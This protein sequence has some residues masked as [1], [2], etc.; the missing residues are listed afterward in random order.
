MCAHTQAE[1]QRKTRPSIQMK[2]VRTQVSGHGSVS[3]A[4][5]GAGS[6]PSAMASKDGRPQSARREATEHSAFTLHILLEAAPL[7]LLSG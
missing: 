5:T 7:L 2:A 3:S 1:D 4:V 6:A